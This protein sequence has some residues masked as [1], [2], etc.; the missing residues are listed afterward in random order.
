MVE[1]EAEQ[2]VT[3]VKVK[4]RKDGSMREIDCDGIFVAIG[5]QPENKPFENVCKLD[6]QGFIIADESTLT[7]EQE[8]QFL[9][10]KSLYPKA[11][12]KFKI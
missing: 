3:G 11:K 4:S 12:I 5:Q 10:E 6:E 1:I 2:F 9:K 8:A 7:S